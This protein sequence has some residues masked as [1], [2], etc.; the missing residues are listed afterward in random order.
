MLATI[1]GWGWYNGVYR[2]F[3]RVPAIWIL[4]D[5]LSDVLHSLAQASSC[6]FF[7]L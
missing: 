7:P 1:E 6:T 3:H 2:S 5:G 4:L